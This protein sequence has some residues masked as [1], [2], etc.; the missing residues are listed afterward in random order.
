MV[1]WQSTPGKL[2]FFLFM[3]T[4]DLTWSHKRQSSGHRLYYTL[5]NQ[6]SWT[7]SPPF[8]P[9]STF[10]LVEPLQA[11]PHKRKWSTPSSPGTSNFFSN[12]E[13]LLL[14]SFN[15]PFWGWTEL[16]IMHVNGNEESFP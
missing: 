2:A 11:K 10:A 14:S 8:V 1:H 7:P 6:P 13:S 16:N 4:N 12:K 3:Q 15:N 5:T 9:P